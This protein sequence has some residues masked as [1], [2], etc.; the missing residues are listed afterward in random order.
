MLVIAG[1]TAARKLYFFCI[2]P[3]STMAMALST[4]VSQNFG[5]GKMDRVRRAVRAANLVALG[6]GAVISRYAGWPPRR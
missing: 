3:I 2:T 6:W 1:H 4:F 5:A